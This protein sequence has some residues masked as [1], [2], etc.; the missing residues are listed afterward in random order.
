MSRR[1]RASTGSDATA[2][3]SNRGVDD[4]PLEIDVVSESTDRRHLLLGEATWT[5]RA[6]P[7]GLLAGLARKARR[8]PFRHGRRLHYARWLKRA[9]GNR[10]DRAS[11]I[12][13]DT[14]VS[15]SRE[16]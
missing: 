7:D 11:V 6:D 1:V 3:E 5:D 4:D 15:A 2:L 13:P 8:V 9:T 14:V 10:V 12:T 16:A